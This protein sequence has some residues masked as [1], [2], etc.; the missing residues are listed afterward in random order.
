[1]RGIA[2]AKPGNTFGDIGHAIQAYAE[3]HRFSIVRDFC[4]HGIGRKF[5]EPP[6]VLHFGRPG[7]GPKLAPG[8]FF[9]IE[10]MVNAGRPEVKILDDGWT[11]V[12]RDRSLSAQFEHMIGITETGCEIFTLSPG[13]PSARRGGS[14]ALASRRNG[15][16]GGENGLGAPAALRPESPRWAPFPVRGRMTRRRGLSEAGGLFDP[17]PVAATPV[18]VEGHRGRMRQKLIEGG[19]DGILDHELIE[20]LL[21]LALPRRDTK[22][23]ARAML[24]RFGSFTV[25]AEYAIWA[26]SVGDTQLAAA[27]RPELERVMQRWNRH[28]RD[29]NAELIRRLDA[30]YAA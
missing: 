13:V 6:N 20:M 18:G 1:M 16:A 17:A 27:Q 25:R 10:P 29:L 24:A 14:A 26:A 4:G 9:T 12:T 22:P 21:F 8:M 5:H 11:A 23:I 19:A 15:R 28:N 2:V 7:E 3:K 30:A